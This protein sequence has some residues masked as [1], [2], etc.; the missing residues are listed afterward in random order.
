MAGEIRTLLV[1]NVHYSFTRFSYD[2]LWIPSQRFC[3]RWNQKKHDRRHTQLVQK[4]MKKKIEYLQSTLTL[5]RFDTVG[6]T[7]FDAM[8]RYAPISRREIFDSSTDSPSHSG[9]GK[10]ITRITGEK[11]GKFIIA[12][13]MVR[14]QLLGEDGIRTMFPIRRSNFMEYAISLVSLITLKLFLC[15]Y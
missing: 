4:W 15:A 1:L 6:G 2:P 3:Y 7:P 9:T 5:I 13:D 8:Q 12:D 14:W 11:K 10:W